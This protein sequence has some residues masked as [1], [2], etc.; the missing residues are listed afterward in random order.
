MTTT[1]SRRAVLAGIAAAPALA[2]RALADPSADA[3]LL[4]LGVELQAVIREWRD[5][6]A[7]DARRDAVR[8]AACQAAG[9][10]SKK[11]DDFSS[12]AECEAYTDKR[13][14]L[15]KA[16]LDEAGLGDEWAREQE[17]E[18]ATGDSV[19]DRF[20]DRMFPLAALEGPPS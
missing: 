13:W 11:Y 18:L 2:A 17:E 10:P 7:L 14:A 16:A 4:A 20:H 19:W 12:R 1:T 8:D 5:R 3:E 6:L 15:K 9:L